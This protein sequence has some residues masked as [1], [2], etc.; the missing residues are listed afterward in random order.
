[1]VDEIHDCA[2]FRFETGNY[3]DA[4]EYLYFYK[5]IVSQFVNRFSEIVY[6]DCSDISKWQLYCSQ[7]V[8]PH[9]WLVKYYT[10][11]SC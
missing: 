10:T 11:I 8:Y 6:L 4:A 7:S 2:K 1:M 9:T 5:Q 3:A